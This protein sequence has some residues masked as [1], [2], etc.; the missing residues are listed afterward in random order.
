MSATAPSA[1]GGDPI[2]R[3][4]WVLGLGGLIPFIVAAAISWAPVADVRQTALVALAAYAAVILSFLGGVRWGALLRDEAALARW[5]P[6]G[7]A[8]LPSLI[9]W[10]ALLLPEAAMLALLFAGLLLQFVLDARAA[11]RGELPRW[12]ARLR[13]ILSTG[14]AA[15]VVAG[16]VAA[17]ALG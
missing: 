10:A 7:L 5:T 3:P 13:V 9:A 2:P 17:I 11:M 1:A 6:L 15:S 8:V 14:A 16:F 12:Y 4:A